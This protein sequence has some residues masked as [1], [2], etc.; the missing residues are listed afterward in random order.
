MFMSKYMFEQITKIM[1]FE[2]NEIKIKFN[3]KN[4]N[5]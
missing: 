4:K 2:F 3:N 5:L 1:Y